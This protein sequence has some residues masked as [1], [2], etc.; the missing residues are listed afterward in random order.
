MWE[1]GVRA[2]GFVYSH[3]IEKPGY[4]SN[5]LIHVSDWLPTIYHVAGGNLSDLVNVE[6]VD[7]WDMISSSGKPVRKELLHNI[8]PISNYSAIRV[9]DYKLVMGDIDGGLYSMWYNCTPP[10]SNSH[11]TSEA[12]TGMIHVECGKRPLNY[13]FNCWPTEAPCLFDVVSDPCEYNNIASGNPQIVSSL[14]QRLFEYASH[15]VPPANK[16]NDPRGDPKYH[17]GVWGPWLP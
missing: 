2:T 13:T 14:L 12:K 11:D 17:G 15:A 5:N 9:G 3:L 8:D 10:N 4:V 6:G 7:L 16:P 1:G